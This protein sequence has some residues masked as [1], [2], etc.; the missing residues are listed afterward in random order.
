MPNNRDGL[1]NQA[2]DNNLPLNNDPLEPL[3]E[4]VADAN[5]IFEQHQQAANED[6]H[7]NP[8]EWDRAAEDLTW[9]R[10]GFQFIFNSKTKN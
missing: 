10:V 4:A 6:N 1:N 8:M 3:I 7:W 2:N 9:D 5:P